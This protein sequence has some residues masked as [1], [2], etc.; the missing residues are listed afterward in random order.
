MRERDAFMDSQS[1]A[2]AVGQRICAGFTGTEI[3]PE[4]ESLIRT[5]KVGN[6][7]LF[8]RN[9]VSFPQLRSLC[10]SLTE[11]IRSETGLPPFIM[12]DE[13]CGP[14]SRVGHLS[15]E[16]PSAG[17]IGSTEDPENARD[18]GA[19]IGRRL[20]SAGVNLNLAPV[21]DVLSRPAS[22]V[23]GNRCFSS[24]PEKVAAFGRAYIEGL[25]SAGVLSCGKHFPG[26]GD[27]DVDS[28]FA[29][30][31]IRKP[32]EEVWNTELVS[33]REAIA[34]GTDDIM[35]A[36]VVYPAI[37]PSGIPATISPRVLRGLLR[38]QLGFD[39]LIISDGMEMQAMRNLFPIPE[40][41]CRALSAG[42]DIALVCHEPAEAA[43]SCLRLRQ[44]VRDGEIS[45]D[46]LAAH[47]SRIRRLKRG[48]F[49]VPGPESDF[50]APAD[51]ADS[52]RI[53]AA[54][55][56]PLSAGPLPALGS[57]PLFAAL[58]SRRA[59]PA[60]EEG[61]L[62]AALYCAA[63]FPGARS[64]TDAASLRDGGS[65][66]RLSG[67]VFFLE[68]GE[69]LDVLKAEAELLASRGLPVIAVALDTP[70]VLSGLSA[71]I[72]T[73]AAWQY[74]RLALDCVIRLLEENRCLD[75]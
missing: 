58:S 63:R 59:S 50:S 1:L 15:G 8:S 22:A 48:L 69:N 24:D 62:N 74:Q 70:H 19:L 18:V 40:G 61:H 16:T 55:V 39:G 64:C 44:A 17:A 33:F 37:D 6:I 30:P 47:D 36:H 20:R 65:V 72:Y 46:A 12:M 29:L 25:R 9:V 5:H 10:G 11:L 67:A 21:L 32:L 51:Q 28:H 73:V 53:M 4:L 31:A 2:I 75:C 43:A 7:L 26:H 34:A 71:G 60:A 49:T 57:A 14:V 45:E 23:M 38:D 66:Q 35:S 68:K 42:V 3:T 54:A 27:T 52:V 13:E 56:R 41:V